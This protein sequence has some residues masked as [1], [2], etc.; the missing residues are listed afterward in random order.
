LEA[1]RKT[2]IAVV[3]PPAA[4][5]ASKPKLR[6][7]GRPPI[8]LMPDTDE[9][10]LAWLGYSVL[11]MIPSTVVLALATA[12]M[13]VLI[14]PLVPTWIVHESFDALLIAIWV[15]QMFRVLYRLL[16]YDYRLTSRNLFRS[17][18]PLYPSEMPLDLASVVRTE[19]EQTTAGRLLGVGMVRVISEDETKNV[20]LEGVR[21]AKSLAGQI[22]DAA[23]AAR[24]R[25]VTAGRV[26][27][28]PRPVAVV[29]RSG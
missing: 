21:R 8:V 16:A 11:A 20:D 27:E 17:R 14:R 22:G 2:G 13:I 15:L 25:N 3:E 29:G 23:T 18:G 26:R 7:G 12:S 24:E 4:S 1:E 5:E 10:D 6:I 9:T 19:V 28:N